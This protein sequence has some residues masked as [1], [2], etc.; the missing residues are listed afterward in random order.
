MFHTILYE[1]RETAGGPVG[2]I[3]LNRPERKNAIS[4]EMA[5]ELL[6]ALAHADLEDRVHCVVLTG[7]GGHFCAGGDFGAMASGQVISTLPIK[8]DYADLLLAMAR[9]PR[10][11][12]ARV[13]GVA[14]GGGLGLVASSHFAVASSTAVF[15]TPEVHRGLF[16]MMIM[17]VLARLV[18]R[19][20]LLDMM[21]N[22]QKIPAAKAAEWD[23]INEHVAPE[24][25][26]VRV[27]ELTSSLA[28][29]SPT[30]VKHGLEAWAMQ[31]DLRLEESLP[32]LRDALYALLGTDDAREGLTAF[33][34]KRAPRWQAR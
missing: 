24:S 5:N 9:Y 11:I 7:A 21:L 20:R 28:S 26:D 8:G 13:E 30:A 6:Y 19:R 29:R 31:G 22:G 2:W 16:P 34:E 18:T 17:A 3:T 4:P 14:M 32:A 15:S 23:L 25:L 10:P 1:R 33:M 12:V 27:E